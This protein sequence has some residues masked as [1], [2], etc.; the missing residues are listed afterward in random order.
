LLRENTKKSQHNEV[1]LK[2]D[3]IIL[4]AGSSNRMDGEDKLF[5]SLL[6]NPVISYSIQLF[7][8]IDLI[9]S[10]TLV[11][12]ESNL[13]QGKRL[14]KSRNWRKI[15]NIA[16]GGKRRQDSVYAGLKK[17][18]DARWTLIHDGARPCID[19]STVVRGVEAASE[20]GASAAGIPINDTVKRVTSEQLV[21]N[22]VERTG[23]WAIQ[24]PQIFRTD[25]ITESHSFVSDDVTDDSSMVELL[26]R[27]VMI[28]KG[29][30]NNIKVTTID[31]L[32]LA[33]AIL[34][35]RLH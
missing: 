18:Q 6:G 28:F 7:E 20:T 1:D 5:Y 30:P 12:S 22:T 17:M 2:V 19:Q 15:R 32:A 29:S 11:F 27:R 23:L 26:G 10:I 34:K 14:I 25:L 16:I 3:A 31:D 9:N 4:A 33:E 8:E 13:H 35:T 21:L 24:T